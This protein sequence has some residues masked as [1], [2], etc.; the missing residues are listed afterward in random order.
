VVIA[1]ITNDNGAAL[2]GE[3]LPPTV[4]PL[5]TQLGV[6]EAF[7]TLAYS[8]SF[9]RYT[10]WESDDLLPAYERQ[11][12]HC[13]GWIINRRGFEQ[14]LWAQIDERVKHQPS[15]TFERMAQTLK[16]SE[17]TAQGWQL[18]LADKQQVNVDFVLDC[19]GRASTFARAQMNRY[20]TSSM[21]A[22][23]DFLAPLNAEV[24]R[25]KGVMIEAV[26]TGWWYSSL[27]PNG[28]LAVAYFSQRC[29]MPKDLCRDPLIW[30]QLLGQTQYTKL[31]IESGEF[32]HFNQPMIKDASM[33]CLRQAGGE[34]W[35]ACGDAAITLDP[36][37]A[38]GMATALWSGHKAA[39]A[40]LATLL[41]DDTLFNQYIDSVK[42]NW[43][44]YSE[45]RAAIYNA[46]SRF[47]DSEFWAKQQVA[48]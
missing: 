17:K 46:Q 33:S 23:C 44:L 19:S 27:L 2:V 9:V 39:Q 41:G 10:C 5:L 34:Q 28:Q 43:Q 38:H 18:T 12:P 29:S 21:V 40:C 48:H 16:H 20:K 22:A 35:L 30:K 37:S 1:P 24:Q 8:P 6:W 11:N 36:L 25:T 26:A 3:S 32:G 14:L 47:V 31:R 45:Q 13:F 7:N 4:I 42:T 15:F